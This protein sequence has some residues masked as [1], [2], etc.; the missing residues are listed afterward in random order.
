MRNY[1]KSLKESFRHYKN[2]AE[3]VQ[4]FIKFNKTLGDSRNT[5]ESIEAAEEYLQEISE[6]NA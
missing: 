5:R 1:K 4:K 3:Y 2:D 6:S